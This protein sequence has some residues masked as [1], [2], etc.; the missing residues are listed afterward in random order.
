VA[1]GAGSTADFSTL[2]ITAGSTVTLGAPRTIGNMI[3]ADTGTATAGSWTIAG[4]GANILTLAGGTPTITVNGLNTSALVTISASIDGTSGLTKAGSGLLALSGSNSYTGGTTISAG[5]L[6]ASN[7][8]AFGTGAVS[9]TS[10]ARLQ[11]NTVTLANAITLNGANALLGN[12]GTSTLT[13][14]VTLGSASTVNLTAN[15]SVAVVFSGTLDL[16]GN[17]LTVNPGSNTGMQVT[18]NGPLVGAGA[19]GISK[20]NTGL[21][22][23]NGNNTGFSGSTSVVLGTLAVGNDGALGSG[24]LNF[25]PG[26]NNTVTI[27][28]ADTSTRTLANV[29]TMGNGIGSTYRFGST[30]VGFTGN[31]RFSNTTAI[32]LGSG[33][34]L[35]DV[36][37]RTQFDAG[38]TGAGG[39]T[40]QV[41][42]GTLVLNGASTYSG[43]T[44]VN[45]GTLLVDGSIGTS[46]VVTVAVGATLGGSGTIGGNTTVS[47]ILAPGAST[48]SL[49]FGGNLTLAS[50]ANAIFEINGV[51]RGVLV[52]GY[53]A[54]DLTNATGLLTY[55]GT[56]TLTMTSLVANGT[57]DL[58]SFTAAAAGSF[59]AINFAGGAYTG[60][61]IQSGSTW[62]ATSAQG[63]VFTFDQVTGDLTV[64]PEPTT[65]VLLG[66]GL[67]TVLFMRRRQRQS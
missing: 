37:N 52:N 14:P 6:R 4:T 21:L 28:S 25:N 13:G 24:V 5:S 31:L 26:N 50:T 60:T 9:V 38:F 34:K 36:N 30:T 67:M 62:T 1:D 56:L 39:I 65:T 2:D 42:T 33:Q 49:A 55:D 22:V 63:Q 10:G 45:A 11:L 53:D 8:F 27:R 58:F 40:M 20:T 51:N 57:Y 19:S 18:I 44:A 29:V 47:G 23:I 41:G 54:I 7:N 35:F 43:T 66:T 15:N 61:F 17:L 59:D 3:F 64:V 48:E 46:S 16:A 32:A 12:T